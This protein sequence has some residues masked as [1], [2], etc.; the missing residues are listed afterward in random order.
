MQSC[1]KAFFRTKAKA[2]VEKVENGQKKCASVRAH[3]Y[4]AIA[5]IEKLHYLDFDEVRK[6]FFPQ[7]QK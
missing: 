1:A 2:V 6:E 7:G 3:I 4:Y 5:K